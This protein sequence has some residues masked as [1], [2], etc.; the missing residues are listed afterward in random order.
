MRCLPFL[1]AGTPFRAELFAPLI[2]L[3]KLVCY[4]SPACNGCEHSH[5]VRTLTNGQRGP[6]P[7]SRTLPSLC[8]TAACATV[9]AQNLAAW[10]QFGFNA[11]H[12]GRSPYGG[13]STSNVTVM[14]NVSTQG[15][16][17]PSAAIGLQTAYLG[18]EDGAVYALD[19]VAG[20]LRWRSVLPVKA[21][22]KSS[23]AIG[24]VGS[25]EVRSLPTTVASLSR[26]VQPASSTHNLWM[27]HTHNHH[28]MWG[29][30]GEAPGTHVIGPLTRGMAVVHLWTA[31][32][33]L[34]H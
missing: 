13:P 22:I 12:S 25:E 4:C 20:G 8:C 14:W 19:I 2:F 11:G 28:D 3:C 15:G 7:L 26:V 34:P 29:W 33:G 21:A 17:W 18:C 1:A 23:P 5:R 24:W 10:P 16:V 31:R 6:I 32:R 27:K 9:V 30:V